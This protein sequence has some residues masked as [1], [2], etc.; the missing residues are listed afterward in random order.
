MRGAVL[1]GYRFDLTRF[2]SEDNHNLLTSFHF[3]RRYLSPSLRRL[4]EVCTPYRL[5]VPALR[6]SFHLESYL[7][8]S[9]IASPANKSETRQKMLAI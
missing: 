3:L 9:S 7:V 5:S 2:I 8:C 6:A 1:V 4:R